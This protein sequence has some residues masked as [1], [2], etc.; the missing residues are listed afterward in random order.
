MN[1]VKNKNGYTLVELL[2]V[3]SIIIMFAVLGGIINSVGTVNKGRD[4]Q[5]KKDLK[6]M[7]TAFE[8]YFNDKGTFPQNVDSW[9][10]K[11]NCGTDVFKPYLNALPCD[12]NGNP[13]IIIVG[14]N[15]FRIITNLEYKK[16]KDI[17]RF[18]YERTEFNL[19]GYR[20]NDINYGVSSSNILWYDG[21]FVD[22]NCDTNN[23]LS[24]E[25]GGCNHVSNGCFGSFC[26]FYDN[27]GGVAC[28]MRCKTFCCGHGCD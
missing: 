24:S 2:I 9:N 25:K 16:D 7:K 23:C 27:G 14:N 11:A 5:R 15:Q 6:I 28:T 22:P 21:N 26:Y 12:P 3:L 8:E 10:I 18:W 20:V 1:I 4:A 13:Y 17:P 19:N